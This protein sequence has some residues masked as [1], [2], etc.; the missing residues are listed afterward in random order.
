M[1]LFLSP[2]TSCLAATLPQLTFPQF[3]GHHP[4]MWKAKTISNSL[5]IPI[6]IFKLHYA[7]NAFYSAKTRHMDKISGNLLESA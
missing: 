2:Y 3:D 1:D 7:N 4:Q 5:R 6:L